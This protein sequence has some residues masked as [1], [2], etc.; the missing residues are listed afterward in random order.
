MIMRRHAAGIHGAVATA[1]FLVVTA[2]VL[3]AVALIAGQG[4]PWPPP[5]AP[6]AALAVSSS[7]RH[8]DG[9]P[10]LLLAA[11]PDR[12]PRHEHARVRVPADR[13]GDRRPV[14]ARSAPGA[15]HVPRRRDHARRSGR[16]A[17]PTEAGRC[18]GGRPRLTPVALG[19]ADRDPPWIFRTYAGHSSAR[20]SNALFRQNLAAGQTG[21]SIAF[22][23]PTQCGY[24]PDHPHRAARGRQGRRADR[25]AR[26][27]ARAVRRASRSSR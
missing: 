16:L 2:I 9:V 14:R 17:P 24:D 21:L 10:H 25:L 1:I 13:P 7:N 23:L 19:M 4:V 20:A 3:G 26:R 5:A 15:A 12:A 11:R 22:D 27:H 6:T 18:G 8:G